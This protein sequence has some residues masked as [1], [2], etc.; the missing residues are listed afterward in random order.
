M[1]WHTCV[2]I[3]DNMS[4]GYI[5]AIDINPMTNRRRR[6]RRRS[7]SRSRRCPSA[8]V[9]LWAALFGTRARGR[10]GSLV[11]IIIIIIIYYMVTKIN[12]C[13]NSAGHLYGTV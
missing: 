2:I 8:A 5:Y 3:Y 12:D 13:V 7:S 9:A 1:R 11:H 10:V 6:R 4:S